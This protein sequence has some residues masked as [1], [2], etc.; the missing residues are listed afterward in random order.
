M[1]VQ[2]ISDETKTLLSRIST[3]TLTSQLLGRGLRNT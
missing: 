1:S 2:A 3:A